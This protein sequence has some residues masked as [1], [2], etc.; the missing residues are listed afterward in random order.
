METGKVHNIYFSATDTTRRV[1]ETI[2]DRIAQILGARTETFDFT[3]PS[4][5]DGF[6]LIEPNAIVV[7]GVPTYAG[8][9]PNVLLKYLDTVRGNGAIAVPVVTYGNRA[10]ENSLVE[11]RDLLETHGFRTVAAGAFCCEHS[12]STTLAA[13]RPNASDLAFAKEFAEKVARKISSEAFATAEHQPIEVTGDTEAGYYQPK[14][15][16][17]AKID[18]RKVKPK[19]KDSCIKCGK[20]ADLCPMGSV[21]HDNPSE[22]TGICIKCCACVKKCPVGAK[23]FDDEGFLYHKHELETR[24]ARPADNTIFI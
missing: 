14:S 7:F 23:Y 10:Y 12:F 2:G 18:I 24:Y 4:A 5:R 1:V 3:L 6:P 20:C 9:I 13:G 16:T 11:L 17:G 19:T 22:I 21:S 8:R 15:S